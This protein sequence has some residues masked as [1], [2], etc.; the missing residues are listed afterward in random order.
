[1]NLSDFLAELSSEPN[2]EW[3]LPH[4]GAFARMSALATSLANGRRA[5]RG[6]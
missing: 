1:M 5:V 3:G 4:S 6:E 2:F